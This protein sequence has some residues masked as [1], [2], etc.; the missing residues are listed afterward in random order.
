[1]FARVGGRAV[2]RLGHKREQ[3]AGFSVLFNVVS[4]TQCSNY[5]STA[6]V[7]ARRLAH[8]PFVRL[9]LPNHLLFL[10]LSQVPVR[11][12][13]P[14]DSGTNDAVAH[15]VF[16]EFCNAKSHIHRGEF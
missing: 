15:S 1:M 4:W 16:P 11:P 13:A 8:E 2:L 9:R 12:Q 5:C 3:M 7:V 10:S 6:P 14:A